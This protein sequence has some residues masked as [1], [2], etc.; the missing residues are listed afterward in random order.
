M[1]NGMIHPAKKR[2]PAP[3]FWLLFG[4]GGMVSA[5][6]GPALILLT[7]VMLPHGWGIP[8]RFG[9][10]A[11]VDAYARNPLGKLMILGVIALFFWHG[12]ERLFLTL[13]DMRAGPLPLLRMATYGVAALVTLLTLTLLLEIGF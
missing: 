7:G 12:A 9:D 2:S 5:L 8:E 13:K 11:H 1:I 3:I 10:F 6:F 4:A